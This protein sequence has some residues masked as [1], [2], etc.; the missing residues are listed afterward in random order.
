MITFQDFLTEEKLPEDKLDE[1][2]IDSMVNNLKWKD[3]EDLYSAEDFD[4]EINEAISPAERLKMAQRT[5]ARKVMLTTARKVKLKRASPMPV[6]KKRSELAAR[7]LIYKRMLKGR[8]K[9]DLSPS[10][11][12]MIELRVKRMMKVYKNLPQKLVPKI[13]ELERQR[14]ARKA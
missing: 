1:Q 9:V 7:K 6:L 12:N 3:I 10:E 11:K 5:R 14:L 4:D 8:T 13:R 2:E